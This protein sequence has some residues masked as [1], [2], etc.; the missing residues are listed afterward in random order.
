[1][2]ARA[3]NEAHQT[4][5]DRRRTETLRRGLR[6]ELGQRLGGVRFCRGI[7]GA[8][9]D[10]HQAESDRAEPL[11]PVE[12][13]RR[14]RRA[15]VRRRDGDEARE[16]VRPAE[17]GREVARVQPA[18]RERD[19]V[20]RLGPRLGENLC[21]A[22]LPRGRS[23]GDG[24]VRVDVRRV[25]P[26]AAAAK[27]HRLGVEH[28]ARRR[29]GERPEAVHQHNRVARRAQRRLRHRVDADRAPRQRRSASRQRRRHSAPATTIASPERTGTRTLSLTGIGSASTIAPTPAPTAHIATLNSEPG[30]A[31]TAS[32]TP[33]AVSA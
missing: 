12:D 33:K 13:V 10:V 7:R 27:M 5:G 2:P 17:F 19:D 22:R 14:E 15:R 21:E 28:A 29:P 4:S 24:V 25:R 31:T 20:Q 30:H 18:G 6:R 11:G 26:D 23:D 8:P 3:A 1:M 32:P 16:V 9:D